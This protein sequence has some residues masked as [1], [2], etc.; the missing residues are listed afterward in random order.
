MTAVID[1]AHLTKTYKDVTALD[2][3]TLQV[4]ENSI[5]GLLGRNG[6]GKT[7]TMSLLTA[8]A[9]PT[10]GRIRVFGEDPYENA[11]VLSHM[12][13]VRESQKYPED[14]TARHA[15]LAASL[16][17]PR[18][19][20]EFARSLVADLRLP[21]DTRIKK[22]S[23]GQLSAVGVVIGLASR[24]PVTFFDEPY[25]GLDAVARS[26]FYKRLLEDYA[27]HPRTIILSSHLI[28]EIADLIDQVILVDDGAL[29]LHESTDDLRGRALTLTGDAE[30][31]DQLV[32]TREVLHRESLGR[33]ASVTVMGS[34]T[35]EEDAE[36]RRLGLEHSAVPLQQ[37]IVHLS[38]RDQ[39]TATRSQGAAS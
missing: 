18:W 23:R 39:R 38:Q 3:L 19:D 30:A 33:V 22:L 8:Q 28:D 10:S 12:C 5:C 20:D 4:E 2:D 32:G 35:D 17:H 7:T 1:V 29:I 24:A 9:L 27:E 16:F 36:A 31:V 25:L 37:L 34:L 15:L 14:F 13:F 11:R 21:L 6:S 26:L